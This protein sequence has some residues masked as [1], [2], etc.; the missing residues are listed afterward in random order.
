VVLP[1]DKTYNFISGMLFTQLF[2]EL[3]YC[4]TQKYKHKGQ[5]LPIPVRF[6]LDEFANTCTI[7]NFIEI[8]AYARSFGIGIV[9]ILQ[10]LEQIKKMYEKDWGV[11][12]DNCNTLLY[13][14]AVTHM[15]T[16]EYIS[17][18][19]GKGT[20]DKKTTG[21]TRG[22]QGSSSQNFDKIGRE[23]MDPAEI[24]KLP[25][26]KC[27][28]IVGGKNPFYSKKY[29]YTSH[30]NYC[31]TSDGGAESYEYKPFIPEAKPVKPET[32]TVKQKEIKPN[33][34]EEGKSGLVLWNDTTVKAVQAEI[35]KVKIE[36]KTAE[37]CLKSISE[38]VEKENFEFTDDC[39]V[40]DGEPIDEEFFEAMD[41]FID[42]EAMETLQDNE[43]MSQDEILEAA[44]GIIEGMKPE[45]ETEIEVA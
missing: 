11:I 26:E 29:D 32:K 16:L 17:K 3:Q 27:L 21:L 12:I 19:L 31:F 13:L 42:D 7:P 1:T 23:L 9:V 30:P 41:E 5:R 20:F 25:K 2:Q 14:G 10:S 36:V 4:A 40:D 8:L 28:L 38:A 35:E 45:G 44:A 37:E 33:K 6:I 22:K 18:L 39:I 15:E 24:R 43:P 34:P